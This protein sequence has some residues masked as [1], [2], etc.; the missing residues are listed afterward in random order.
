MA[1]PQEVLL[2]RARGGRLGEA[3]E[4]ALKRKELPADPLA[5]QSAG[6][7]PSVPLVQGSQAS[8]VPELEESRVLLGPLA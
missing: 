7:Q 3:G 1:L 2:P 6:R 5:G 4:D 8:A